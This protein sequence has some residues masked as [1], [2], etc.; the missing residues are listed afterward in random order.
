MATNFQD[1]RILHLKVGFCP[2]KI[3]NSPDLNDIGVLL[4]VLKATGIISCSFTAI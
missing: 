2:K 3:I 4:Y 1:V